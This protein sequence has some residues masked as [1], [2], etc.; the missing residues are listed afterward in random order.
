[1]RMLVGLALAAVTTAASIHGDPTADFVSSLAPT[2]QASDGPRP[3]TNSTM[4]MRLLD[5][6]RDGLIDEA[7]FTAWALAVTPEWAALVPLDHDE[8]PAAVARRSLQSSNSPFNNEAELH[9]CED[10]LYHMHSTQP[11]S[12]ITIHMYMMSKCPF[13]ARA[14]KALIPAMIQ[15]QVGPRPGWRNCLR[16]HSNGSTLS[17]PG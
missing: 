8:P 11:G 13:A 5:K 10:A 16:A 9:A 17:H 14:L 12:H 2:S 15:M 6:N 1:M 4:D 7:E 3:C